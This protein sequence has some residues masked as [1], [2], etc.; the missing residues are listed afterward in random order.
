MYFVIGLVLSR[1]ESSYC[2]ASHFLLE[3]EPASHMLSPLCRDGT[4]QDLTVGTVMSV[5]QSQHQCVTGVSQSNLSC[6]HRQVR[7]F[8]QAR[9]QR[10]CRPVGMS[11]QSQ[12]TVPHSLVG[13]NFVSLPQP[14]LVAQ[15][16][17]HPTQD[18]PETMLF[19]HRTRMS[20]KFCFART[21]FRYVIVQATARNK[22]VSKAAC[23]A[24]L[25]ERS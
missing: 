18:G 4:S 25:E 23:R 17:L 1:M 16:S 2:Q 7:N 24:S 9:R 3:Q 13:E 21:Y 10:S 22:S 12:R 6:P 8:L 11:R 5:T 15:N 14:C 19:C 20:A